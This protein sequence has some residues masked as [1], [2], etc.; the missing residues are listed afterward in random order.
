MSLTTFVQSVQFQTFQ[1]ISI[2]LQIQLDDSNYHIFPPCFAQMKWKIDGSSAH[3]HEHTLQFLHFS[4][5]YTVHIMARREKNRPGFSHVRVFG[6]QRHHFPRQICAYILWSRGAK[7]QGGLGG[8]SRFELTMGISYL[9]WTQ[10]RLKLAQMARHDYSAICAHNLFAVYHIDK[11]SADNRTLF[12]D[13]KMC[14]CTK[15]SYEKMWWVSE[16]SHEK[17]EW[18][19][20]W[21]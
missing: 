12:D 21:Y 14:E 15:I 18:C 11:L 8:S 3:K 2:F 9:W 17:C 16:Y 6:L 20:L 10:T 7:R 4:Q 1:A 13:G 19:W 5:Q